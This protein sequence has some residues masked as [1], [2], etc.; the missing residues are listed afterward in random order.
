[1]P[2]YTSQPHQ[3]QA[4]ILLSQTEQTVRVAKALADAGRACDL[5]GLDQLAGI[6]CAK[7]L[8]L[9]PDEGRA[10][11]AQVTALLG[12]CDA[13]R[14]SLSPPRQKADQCP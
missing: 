9:P 1:M 13:L 3:S 14:A 4:A 12:A 11:R 5:S 6:A 2:D 8:D 7:A 10:L